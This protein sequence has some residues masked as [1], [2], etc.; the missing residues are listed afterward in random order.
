MSRPSST[1]P[2]ATVSAAVWRTLSRA[3][4]GH[5]LRKRGL[6]AYG[7]PRF[8]SRGKRDGFSFDGGGRT[9][10]GEYTAADIKVLEGLD[11]VRKRPAMYIGSTGASGLHHRLRGGRQRRRRGARRAL[12]G[13]RGDHPRRQ[14]RDR[15]RRRTGIPTEPHPEKGISTTEVV[16]TELHSGGKF[17]SKAYRVS[18]GLH[19]VGVTGRELPFREARGRDQAR[20]PRLST[21]LRARP[22]ARSPGGTGTTQG[23][24]TRITFK[25]DPQVFEETEYSYDTL[26]GR[27]RELAFLNRGLRISLADERTDRT[28]IF[29]LR[30]R[31][32]SFVD[33]INKNKAPLHPPISLSR[34]KDA[35]RLDL[36][37]QYNDSYTEN[38]FSFANNINTHEGGTHLAGFKAALT[39]TVNQYAVQSG[40]LKA[41]KETPIQG[42]DVR[43]GL[44]AVISIQLPN[45][46]FEGQT[47]TK[48]GNS[49]VKGIVEAAVNDALGSF[50][51][52]NPAVARKIVE[53]VLYAARAREAARKARDLT[54][55]KGR[56]TRLP[57][58]GSWPTA[59]KETRPR[60]RFSSSR[61][62][63]GR[64][65]KAGAGPAVPGDPSAQGE[66]PERGEGPDRQNAL[67][68]GDQGPH[69]GARLR[70]RAGRLRHLAPSVPPDHHH[71]GRRRGRGP[72]SN[73]APHLFFR[74]M[75]PL[76][77]KGYLFIA[78]PPLYRIK[79]GEGRTVREGREPAR[80]PSHRARRRG[81]RRPGRRWRVAEGE[82]LKRMAKTLLR[83]ERSAGALCAKEARSGRPAGADP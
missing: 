13:G 36:A 25:P 67:L 46:Q 74:Q 54:R 19:G 78:Q 35:V 72:H 62:L 58:R 70:R 68:G 69:Y 29:S 27:L 59:R 44:A 12:H 2:I 63:R 53:K 60:A 39:R 47:K 3:G 65:R 15:H 5:V 33:H 77:E 30:G 22:P 37:L 41:L 16:L 31:I 48:L 83:H 75:G 6:A 71:D 24:G 8:H 20:R 28:Q 32:V 61:R 26:A 57:C 38:I 76:V 80:G 11:A 9:M 14:Q 40:L 34:E 73:P 66:D 4:A 21:A 56:S 42:E 10:S 82:A 55:R 45:P 43:E 49:E 18:G 79:K 17:E 50:F 23:R 7:W 64:L 81:D 52:E 1:G 51:E